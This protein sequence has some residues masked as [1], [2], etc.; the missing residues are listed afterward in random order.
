MGE[1]KSTFLKEKCGADTALFEVTQYGIHTLWTRD[2]V[3][4]YTTIL[5]AQYEESQKDTTKSS[6]A[7]LASILNLAQN[8]ELIHPFSDGNL[9]VFML[10]SE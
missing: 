8:L 3:A 9:R 10:N 7:K 5:L 1:K 4:K 2:E 6:E